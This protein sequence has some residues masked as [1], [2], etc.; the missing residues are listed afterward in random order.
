[1]KRFLWLYVVL[2][3]G[4]LLG[5][6]GVLSLFKH[7][8][9]RLAVVVGLLV[10]PAVQSAAITLALAGR[11][12]VDAARAFA[13]SLTPPVALLLVA[14]GLIVVQSLPSFGWTSLKAMAAGLVFVAAALLGGAPPPARAAGAPPVVARRT[15]NALLGLAVFAWGVDTF[16]PWIAPLTDVVLH[17]KPQVLRWIAV[18]LPLF[19]GLAALVLRASRGVSEDS[20]L[21]L[22]LALALG[23]LAALIAVPNLYLR[24]RLQTPWVAIVGALRSGA[25]TFLLSGALL[26]LR[27]WRR[28]GE[29][30]A[31]PAAPAA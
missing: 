29:G 25:A 10:I 17:S 30:T 11:K 15:V 14:D 5:V 21:H 23:F 27:Q 18:G 1:M 22:E 6:V 31:V 7:I 19:A 4:H 20:A 8:D 26:A 2:F 12:S 3:V 16:R 28:P 9:I 24:P 13:D